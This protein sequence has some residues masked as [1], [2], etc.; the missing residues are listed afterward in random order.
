MNSKNGTEE[1]TGMSFTMLF[2][3]GVN[4]DPVKPMKQHTPSWHKEGVWLFFFS[5]RCVCLPISSPSVSVSVI[6]HRGASLPDI[7]LCLHNRDSGYGSGCETTR[8]VCRMALT[9]PVYLCGI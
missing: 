5:G 6:C 3:D 4:Y 8:D 1:T 2:N 9:G 7:F